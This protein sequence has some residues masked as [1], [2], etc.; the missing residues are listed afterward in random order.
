MRRVILNSLL[1]V[2][3]AALISANWILRA[4]TSQRNFEVLPDMAHSIAYDS[5]AANPNFPDG[6]TLRDPVPGTV[7]REL[8]ESIK[9]V[10]SLERG[11]NVFRTYCEICHGPAG[12]GDG[13]VAQRGFPAPPSLLAARAR[14]LTDAQIFQII[15]VGQK[16][17]PS[18][19]SQVDR[20]DRWNAILYVRDL[21]RR[22][23]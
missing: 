22:N 7:I 12:R 21:Q 5:F 17:M 3:V 23:R 9:P 8:N 16:N 13:T 11:G 4:N 10:R 2:I 1:L 19:A 18:Y 6:K 20:D 14:G 15:T